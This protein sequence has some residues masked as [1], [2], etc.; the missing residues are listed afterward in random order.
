MLPAETRSPSFVAVGR[1]VETTT[2][3]PVLRMTMSS[4]TS[5]TSLGFC[6]TSTIDNPLSFNLRMVAITSAT[7]CGARP[8]DGSSISSTRGLPISARPIA[9]ICCSPPDRCAAIWPV[10][11]FRRGNIANTVSAVQRRMLAAGIGLARGDH[12]IFAHA[13]AFENAPALRHQRHAARRD[14]FGRQARHVGAE[15]HDAAFARR[16]QAHGDGHAGGFAGAVAAEQAEQCAPRRRRR[17]HRAAHGCRRNR[18]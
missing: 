2:T 7:I 1:G 15:N 12:Q 14:H 10:R 17:K 11:S 4:A 6:S 9:S 18:R 3:R 8:S 13:Q 5:N 16:Q